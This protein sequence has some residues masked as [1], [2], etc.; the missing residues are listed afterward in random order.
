MHAKPWQVFSSFFII[1]KAVGFGLLIYHA[2][3]KDF[4]LHAAEHEMW[5]SPFPFPMEIEPMGWEELY[6]EAQ[7]E[8]EKKHGP[9]DRA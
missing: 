1:L 6:R 9:S 5:G 8:Y 2:I 7:E 3:M 4:K